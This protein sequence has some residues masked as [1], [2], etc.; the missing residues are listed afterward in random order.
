MTVA[1][2]REQYTLVFGFVKDHPSKKLRLAVVDKTTMNLL[3]EI[4]ENEQNTCFQQ[5][6]NGKDLNKAV[7]K[8][9]TDALIEI[10]NLYKVEDYN[11]SESEINLYFV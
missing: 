3:H 9:K 10:L 7:L 5:Y 6:L 2:F 8:F 11:L 1:T 4:I